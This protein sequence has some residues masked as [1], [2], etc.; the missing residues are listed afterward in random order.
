M[1]PDALVREK[2]VHIAPSDIAFVKDQAEAYGRAVLS[3]LLMGF[4][5]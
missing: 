5:G 4:C 3:F 2:A 1:V